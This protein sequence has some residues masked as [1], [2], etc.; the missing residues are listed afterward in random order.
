MILE[1]R[2]ITTDSSVKS[3]KSLSASREQARPTSSPGLRKYE[4]SARN[5]HR[6][7]LGYRVRQDF[8]QIRIWNPQR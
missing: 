8:T 5:D 6:S 3:V 4:R 1:C 7:P 2:S